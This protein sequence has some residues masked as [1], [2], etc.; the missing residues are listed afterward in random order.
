M[1][2]FAYMS[3]EATITARVPE[4]LEAKLERRAARERR[5]LS[6]QITHELERALADELPA[7]GPGA[8]LGRC[9]GGPVPTSKDFEEVPST[10][11]GRLSHA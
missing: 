10:L 6:A 9:S 2:H 3:K 8:I 5:S 1:M 11:W 4:S 7:P